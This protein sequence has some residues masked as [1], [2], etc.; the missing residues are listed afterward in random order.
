M[1]KD[2]KWT[3]Q[4]NYAPINVMPHTPTGDMW[5]FVWGFDLINMQITHV[6]MVQ[7]L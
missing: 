2:K 1:I 3:I 5:G 7:I 6:Y 4:R